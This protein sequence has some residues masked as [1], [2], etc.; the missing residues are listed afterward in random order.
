[1]QGPDK[2]SSHLRQGK[3][4]QRSHHHDEIQDVP[5]VS[6]VGAVL[7]DQ[8]LINHLEGRCRE[9]NG[10]GMSSSDIKWKGQAGGQEHY[11]HIPV[12]RV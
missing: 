5:E 12:S 4:H 11:G 6:E 1:M 3:S 7:Q 2:D 9:K 10:Q 8:A